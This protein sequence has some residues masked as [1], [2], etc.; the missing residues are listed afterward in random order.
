MVQIVASQTFTAP[1]WNWDIHELGL[2]GISGFVGSV[3]S[4]F[5]GGRL[6]DL[7]ATRM[8]ASRG[9]NPQPEYRLPAMIIP[10]VV[11]PMGMLV[12]GLVIA[13]H[14]SWGGAAV[15]YG[16]EGFGA[17]AA[18]NVI[19][20]YAVDAYRPVSVALSRHVL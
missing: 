7:I 15:G 12:Y 6:I 16:M 9:E 3:V 18:A 4:F 10:A 20:T 13:A 17:T 11:G 14:G 5:V 8:T 2:L 19:I 1:P